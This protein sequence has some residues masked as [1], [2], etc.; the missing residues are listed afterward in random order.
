[1]SR[2]ADDCARVRDLSARC[3]CGAD[4]SKWQRRQRLCAEQDHEGHDALEYASGH[5]RCG[6]CGA[7]YIPEQKAS[8][9][10]S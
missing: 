9:H 7:Y 4:E 5:F 2:H 3:S 6:G 10:E 8:D 1:M